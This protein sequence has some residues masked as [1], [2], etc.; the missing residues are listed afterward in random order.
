MVGSVY[1]PALS[2]FTVSSAAADA[3]QSE[4]TASVAPIMILDVPMLASVSA[5]AARESAAPS[6]GLYHARPATARLR[7]R[8][9][10]GHCACIRPSAALIEPGAG[11][12]RP[13]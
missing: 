10:R 2:G 9:P 1:T 6:L 13:R 3:A 7:G 4:S 5:H 12:L 11:A 8:G